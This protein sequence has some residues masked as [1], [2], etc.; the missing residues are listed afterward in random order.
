MEI[1]LAQAKTRFPF[2][3]E[4][5]KAGEEITIFEEG[6]PVVKMSPARAGTHSGHEEEESEIAD[7]FADA[8]GG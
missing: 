8:K 1:D 7:L 3:I 2:L 5:T 6:L 4:R